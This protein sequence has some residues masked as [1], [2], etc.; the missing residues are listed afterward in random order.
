M[1]LWRSWVVA[2]NDLD[3]F[4]HKKYSLYSLVALP[5]VLSVGLPVML[6]LLIQRNNASALEV[7]VL[8]N[9]FAFI[10]IVLP[11]LLPT[12]LASYSFVGEKL[13]RSLEPLLSTPATDGELLLGKGLAAFLPSLLATYLG[14][15]VFVV[16][17]DQ[18]TGARV[19]FAYFPNAEL[20][21]ILMVAA[22]LAC[23]FSVEVNVMISSL[24]SDLRAAQQLGVLVLVPIG[25][26]YVL[27]ETNFL[28]LSGVSLLV[29]SAFLAALDLLLFFL[30]RGTFRREKIL[31][32]WK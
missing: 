20:E 9:A 16:L 14:A 2:Q 25:G 18:L 31:T 27:A 26:L 4:A 8:L 10:F 1:K 13:D 29:V 17:A 11:S 7:E 28:S 19:G 24:V 21:A 15:G 5:A 6:W 23:I 12:I 22:P 32:E 30:G 3:V